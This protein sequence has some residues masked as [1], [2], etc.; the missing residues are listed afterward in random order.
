MVFQF[1]SLR[2]PT[3][4]RLPLG[5]EEGQEGKE[6]R[7]RLDRPLGHEEEK[8]Q[9]V[10]QVRDSLSHRGLNSIS[11]ARLRSL[12]RPDQKSGRFLF[13]H[14]YA[15]CT[16]C[17]PSNTYTTPWAIS[18]SGA[19]AGLAMLRCASSPRA[20]PPWATATVSR[21]KLSYHSLTRLETIL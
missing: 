1:Y 21:V 2:R 7:S 8:V 13:D 20:V 17:L 19:A 16:I 12:K 9:K 11:T 15:Y 3:S 14:R 6:V 18:T 5:Q 10:G 4:A